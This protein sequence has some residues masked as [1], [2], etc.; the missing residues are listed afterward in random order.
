MDLRLFHIATVFL[1]VIIAESCTK[2]YP[3]IDES[4]LGS[5]GE[6]RHWSDLP[7]VEITSF[8]V[9]EVYPQNISEG[10][11]DVYFTIELDSIA[12]NFNTDSNVIVNVGSVVEP[13]PY[14]YVLTTPLLLDFSLT[15]T[16]KTSIMKIEI[17][18]QDLGGTDDLLERSYIYFDDFKFMFIRNIDK[19]YLKDEQ[20][21]VIVNLSF[22]Q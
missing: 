8:T 16:S 15:D 17:W 22:V 20:I 10:Y 4:I 11:P 1:I 21:I 7:N 18:D 14:E 12:N 2:E 9:E 3:E 19:I 5:E 13:T 6:I